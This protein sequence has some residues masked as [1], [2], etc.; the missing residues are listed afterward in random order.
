ME[1]TSERIRKVRK[2]LD[3]TLEEFADKLGVTKQ[4][5][6]HVEDG[7]NNL[8][9]QLTRRICREYHVNYEYLI[10]G[11]G[12]MFGNLQE[13]ILNELSLHYNL[14]DWDREILSIYLDMPK[15]MK[16]YIKREIKKRF[17]SDLNKSE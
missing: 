9:E 6:S 14:D 16:F 8:T 10:Y 3:L 2:E 7:L 4:T 1:N 11:K 17:F 12:E 13:T 5:I 15:E